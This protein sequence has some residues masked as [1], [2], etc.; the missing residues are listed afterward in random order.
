MP[1]PGVAYSIRGVGSEARLEAARLKRGALVWECTWESEDAFA[2]LPEA[3]IRSEDRDVIVF[4]SAMA[5]QGC[6]CSSPYN[7]PLETWKSDA[8]ELAA[9]VD[10]LMLSHAA[11]D[12]AAAGLVPDAELEAGFK[13]L[14]EIWRRETA[15]HSSVTKKAMH[16]AYQRIIGMGRSA[17]PLILRELR[18]KPEHWFWALTAITGEDPVPEEDAGDIRKMAQAWLDLGRGRGWL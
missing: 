16:E 9:I 11:W 12:E 10:V 15:V 5:A 8:L 18:D 14:A 2:G 1:D 13:R 3:E 6:A 4:C 17:V 7:W